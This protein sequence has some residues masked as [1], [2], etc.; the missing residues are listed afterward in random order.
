MKEIITG[1]VID[2]IKQIRNSHPLVHMIPNQVTAALCG[3]ALAALGARPVM[4]VA[5]EEMREVV[6]ASDSLVVNTGQPG[7]EK[8][9]AS[10]YALNTAGEAG[11]PV[12]LDPVGAGASGYRHREIQKL[13]ALEWKGVV[14]GNVSEIHA[15]QTESLVYDGVDSTK[16]LA[17]REE[18]CE[19]DCKGRVWGCTG[20]I[21]RIVGKTIRVYLKHTSKRSTNLVG[22]GCMAGALTGAFIATGI[23]KEA[24]L[25]GA[26]GLVSFI[27]SRQNGWNEYG[28]YKEGLLNG[29]SSFDLAEFNDYLLSHLSVR[30]KP[31]DSLSNLI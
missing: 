10:T 19:N 4:A 31:E 9:L 3:D 29:I 20:E 30:K 12:V 25:A 16:G 8:W 7:W 24:A 27:E 14:K 26:L 15:L 11:I 28:R 1:Q 17:I 18:M 23:C 13:M 5:P 21:D 6:R 2:G 22:T